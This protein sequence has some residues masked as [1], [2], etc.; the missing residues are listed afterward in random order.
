MEY[1]KSGL[2][3]VDLA[4]RNSGPSGAAI[5]QS[6]GVPPADQITGIRVLDAKS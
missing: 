5:A 6:I 1:W 4:L 3:L 2:R